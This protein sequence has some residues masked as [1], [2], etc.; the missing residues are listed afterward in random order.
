VITRIIEMTG[1]L[2]VA[3]LI[4]G[5]ADVRTTQ[6]YIHLGDEHPWEIH[7]SRFQVEAFAF[8]RNCFSSSF[9]ID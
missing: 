5:H 2:S 9:A 1:D 7:C 4:A 3:Q 6:G 8:R